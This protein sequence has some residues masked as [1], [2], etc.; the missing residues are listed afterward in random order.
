[1]AAVPA[2]AAPAALAQLDAVDVSHPF[3]VALTDVAA[4]LATMDLVV[5]DFAP[6]CLMRIFAKVAAYCTAN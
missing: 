3:D 6:G 5:R 2:L 4:S 1:M